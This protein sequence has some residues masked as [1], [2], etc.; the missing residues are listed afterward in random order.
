MEPNNWSSKATRDRQTDIVRGWGR[1]AR[2]EC[3]A[4]ADWSDI[5][6]LIESR[7]TQ[8][9]ECHVKPHNTIN[10][11]HEVKLA[12]FDLFT[13]DTSLSIK[14]KKETKKTPTFL[15]LYCD[16]NG[17]FLTASEQTICQRNINLPGGKSERG[18]LD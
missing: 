16:R 1:V 15:S 14:Q 9:R 11:M 12:D 3:M 13:E 4:H 7:D 2:G 10:N 18:E 8:E 6:P 5:K 17:S